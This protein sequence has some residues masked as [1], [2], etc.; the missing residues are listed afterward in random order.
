[1]D[2]ISEKQKKIIA[3]FAKYEDWEERYKRIIALGKELEELPEAYKTEENRIKGCQSQVWLHAELQNGQIIYR[4]DSDAT[5]VRGLAAL[6][7]SVFSYQTPQDI[8][9]AS[10]DFLKEIGLINNLSQSRANGLGSMIR[11]FKN[12]AVAFNVLQ[13]Q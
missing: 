1:M 2:S 7:V 6:L 12:Y 5:I 3:E 8:M 10:T 9:E 4:A 11:Q 13:Q